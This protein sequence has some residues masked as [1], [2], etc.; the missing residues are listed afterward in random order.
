MDGLI[1]SSPARVLFSVNGF[2]VY[3]YG[4]TMA[5]AIFCGVFTSNYFANISGKFSK[6]IFL[7]VAPLVIICGLLGAR[8]WYC[9]INY[10]F[11]IQNP[12]AMLNFREGGISIHGAIFGGAIA[13]WYFARKNKFKWQSLFDY[14][15]LGLALGQSIGRWGN[16]F[17]NEA[18]GLPSDAWLK[19]YIPLQN[20][21]EAFLNYEYFHPT[22][23]Y[24]SVLDFV[25]FLLLCR[26]LGKFPDGKLTLLYLIAYS[27]I[28]FFLEFLRIDST[29]NF[30]IITFPALVSLLVF[31]VSIFVLIKLYK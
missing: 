30:G 21:P 20:R 7:N 18:F 11:Y 12:A 9:G 19:L 25:L 15:V 31:I 13:L 10:E 26:L 27:V 14:A 28:R 17:N 8:L 6:D 5:L 16:F 2:E 29:L 23:L 22:F 24:E 4:L 3:I 1:L